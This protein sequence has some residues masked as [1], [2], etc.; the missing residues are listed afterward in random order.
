M[1]HSSTHSPGLYTVPYFLIRI[2]FISKTQSCLVANLVGLLQLMDDCHYQSLWDQLG[3]RKSLKDFILRIFLVYRNLVKQEVFSSD[4][5]VMKMVM[6]NVLLNSLH[7]ITKPL[8]RYFL[9]SR[10]NFD[11]QVSLCSK[12]V[13]NRV[14]LNQ[15]WKLIS[16]VWNNYFNLAVEFLTQPALQLEKFSD[17]KHE[18][19]IEKYGDMRVL[20]GYQILKVWSKLGKTRIVALFLAYGVLWTLT[21]VLFVVF[22]RR[23]Q[24]EFHTSHGGTI[25]RGNFSA[26]IWSE[27]SHVEYIFRHDANRRKS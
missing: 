11:S 7:E 16:Q 1:F 25:F 6:N 10:Y 21:S 23:A 5:L 26:G 22:D 27:E 24:S 9:D 19:I 8:I 14:T 20:M 3:D 13:R 18:K 2:I 4:W 15:V 17:V 12:Y